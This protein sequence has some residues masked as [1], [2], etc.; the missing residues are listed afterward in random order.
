M[1]NKYPDNQTKLPCIFP[2]DVTLFLSY[3]ER[4]QRIFKR[5]MPYIIQQQ[6]SLSECLKP[7]SNESAFQ[8]LN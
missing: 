6:I 8:I 1:Y 2:K 7:K 3:L 4:S 5:I